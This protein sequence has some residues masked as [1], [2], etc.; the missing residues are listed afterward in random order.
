MK[1]TNSP[2][3]ALPATLHG[4]SNKVEFLPRVTGAGPAIHRWEVSMSEK[5]NRF[6][7]LLG[8]S[9]PDGMPWSVRARLRRLR[10]YLPAE[11]PAVGHFRTN[12]SLSLR[13]FVF[14]FINSV[15]AGNGKARRGARKGAALIVKQQ[16]EA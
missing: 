13:N 8:P 11:R 2:P 4:F 7:F 10:S 3:R 9:G 5:R 12:C 15:T 14:Q 1:L 16:D 6:F